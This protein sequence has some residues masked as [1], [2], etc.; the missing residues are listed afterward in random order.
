VSGTGTTA[1]GSWFQNRA[2]RDRPTRLDCD[3]KL[4]PR[5]GGAFFALR[6]AHPCGP[7]A[8]TAFKGQL[9]HPRLWAK[10]PMPSSRKKRKEN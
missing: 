2:R 4:E 1:H 8:D 7:A 3:E 6:K 5:F 10:I 9:T